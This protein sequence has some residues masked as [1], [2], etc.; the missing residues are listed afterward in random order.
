MSKLGCI[1]DKFDGRDYLMRAYL[2]AMKLPKIVDYTKKMSPV[3]DQGDEGTCVGFASSAGMKEYQE[4]LDYGRMIELSPR[5]VYNECK[6]IDG[7]PN[8]E[9]TTI[10]AAMEIL[11]KKGICRER[12]WPYAP[13]QKDRPKKGASKD[14]KRFKVLTYAR[15]LN[16]NELKL[17]LVLKGP[18]VIGVVVFSGMFEAKA[19][20][21]PMPGKYEKDLGGHAI[22]PVAYDDRKKLIKFK[23]SW[24]AKWGDKGYGYLPYEYINLYMLD[25]WSSVDID[26]P[27]PLTLASVLSYANSFKK[28]WACTFTA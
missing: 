9:G 12:Y 1:K 26:D 7:M 8:E 27:N 22:C 20:V 11:H 2:P 10:R 16:I 28:T 24:S 23:N 4:K 6:K 15:I 21:I 18:C 5:F 25:A 19:G 3:R 14:A 17:S 13:H